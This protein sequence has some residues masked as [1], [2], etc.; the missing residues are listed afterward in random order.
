MREQ[1]RLSL[2]TIL[3][4]KGKNSLHVDI[5]FV[6]YPDSVERYDNKID[7]CSPD[8]DYVDADYL[9]Y[10]IEVINQDGN[11]L[12]DVYKYDKEMISGDFHEE[13]ERQINKYIIEVYL[14]LQ[15]IDI[16]NKKE[17]T[18]E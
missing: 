10:D 15:D 3:N 4:P 5:A 2:Q 18:H 12:I 17:A 8:G 6:F 16:L 1:V 14:G 7:D 11:N 9:Q 13:I